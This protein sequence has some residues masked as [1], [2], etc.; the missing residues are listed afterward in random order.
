MDPGEPIRTAV[1]GAGHWG[2][3][4]IRNFD[5]PPASVV[6][7]VV[8]RRGLHA[9]PA[10]G[11]SSAAVP[12]SGSPQQVALAMLGSFG[13]SSSQFSCLVSLWARESGWNIYASNPSSGNWPPID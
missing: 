5:S 11:S 1:L 3:N 7:V 4:L 9:R 12:P 2:P 6:K 8:D 10:T 13:W